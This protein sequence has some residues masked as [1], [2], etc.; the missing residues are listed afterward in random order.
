MKLHTASEVISLT[1]RLEDETGRFYEKLASAGRNPQ[2]WYDY[3]K[4]NG[5]NVKNVERAYNDVISDALEGGFAFDIEADDFELRL[6][7][8]LPLPA[9]VREAIDIETR[10]AGLYTIAAQQSQSLLPDVSRA[11]VVIARKR[12]TRIESLTAFFRLSQ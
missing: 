1:R 9:V 12:R 2:P 10:L 5:Q 8:P 11:M 3:V 6:P 7:E 4:E